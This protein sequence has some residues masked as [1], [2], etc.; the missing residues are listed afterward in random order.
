[1]LN[2]DEQAQENPFNGHRKIEYKKPKELP[3]TKELIENLEI[4]GQDAVEILKKKI[5]GNKK[6][7]SKLLKK[8]KEAL[9]YVESLSISRS[10]QDFYKTINLDLYEVNKDIEFVEKENK[11]M[12]RAIM[13]AGDGEFKEVVTGG[14]TNKDIER[15]LEYPIPELIEL[16]R[17]GFGKSIWN[18][19]EKTPSMK[20]YKDSNK[21]YC[22][23]T[24]QGG[25]V[26]DVAMV[27]YN[28]SFIE[29]VKF[30][31]NN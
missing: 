14:V 17:G 7:L 31:I 15:A 19:G 13:V 20:Y 25:S 27:L 30:L 6:E 29:A 10:K 24:N 8:R 4:Y 12:E 23:S 28:Y 5:K 22:F 1:M 3:I 11:I 18:P 2:M 21:V 26:I 9:E 16:N